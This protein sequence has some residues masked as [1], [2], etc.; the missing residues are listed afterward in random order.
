[1]VVVGEEGVKENKEGVTFISS[2]PISFEKRNKI[3]KKF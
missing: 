3:E 1:M 2:H